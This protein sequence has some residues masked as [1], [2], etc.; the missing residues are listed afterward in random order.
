MLAAGLFW[1]LVVKAEQHTMPV[2]I[3]ILS[4]IVVVGLYGGWSV[5]KNVYFM[6]ALPAFLA[7]IAT[8]MLIRQAT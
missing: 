5:G 7:L 8:I 2:R 1:T 6:Q 3:Y 4:F